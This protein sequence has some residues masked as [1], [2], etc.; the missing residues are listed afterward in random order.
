MNKFCISKVYEKYYFSNNDLASQII[1]QVFLIAHQHRSI[2][3][4]DSPLCESIKGRS[5]KR[6]SN[7]SS[8]KHK[9]TLAAAGLY[10]KKKWAQLNRP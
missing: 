10:S 7:R 1:L 5:I 3:F 6:R 9:I 4:G 8:L 2:K